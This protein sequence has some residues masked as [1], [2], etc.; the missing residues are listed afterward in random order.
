MIA[1][2]RQRATLTTILAIAIVANAIVLALSFLGIDRLRENALREA[3][4]RSQNLALAVDLALTNEISKIDLSLKTVGAAL[5]SVGVQENR[6]RDDEVAAL[7]VQQKSLLPE[8]EG[9]S[10]TNAKGTGPV[11]N[12]V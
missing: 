1:R 2:S 5:R 7:V 9:W 3:E 10:I 6:A 4:V 8:T 11:L 12:F